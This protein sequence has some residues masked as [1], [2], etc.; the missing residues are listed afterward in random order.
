MTAERVYTQCPKAL[1]RS[2]L[3]NPGQHVDN[4]RLPSSGTMIQALQPDFDADGYDA[5][6]SAAAEGDDLLIRSEFAV[7]ADCGRYC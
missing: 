5:G 7:L 2:R 6:L 1:V 4:S 3:W